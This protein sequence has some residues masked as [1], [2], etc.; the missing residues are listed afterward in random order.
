MEE[1]ASIRVVIVIMDILVT[2]KL[3]GV[4]RVVPLVMREFTVTKL[5][6]IRIMDQTAASFAAKVV[7]TKRVML[8]VDNV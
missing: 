4:P 5:A 1:I 7:L 2:R 6:N 3:D 8:R